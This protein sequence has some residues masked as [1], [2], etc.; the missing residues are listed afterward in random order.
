MT[1]LTQL[2]P[3]H[4]REVEVLDR[5]LDLLQ[6]DDVFN[7][8]GDRPWKRIAEP[9]MQ[10]L[11]DQHSMSEEEASWALT[12][13]GIAL[14]EITPDQPGSPL[15]ALPSESGMSGAE[16]GGSALNERRPAPWLTAPSPPLTTQR[17][18]I[19]P[20]TMV[21]MVIAIAVG[22]IASSMTFRLVENAQKGSLYRNQPAS[23]WS[24]KLQEPIQ[25][26]EV[27]QGHL[28]VLKDIDPA[29]DLRHGD[30]EAIP[31]LIELLKD[32]NSVV[33][34]EAILILGRIGKPAK[35]A[36]PALQKAL[37][38]PDDQVRARA[39]TV[40]QQLQLELAGQ[41]SGR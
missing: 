25:R 15:Q 7:S 6:A 34:Q 11:E 19:Q 12:S 10:E 20:K 40:I 35:D 29:A 38:D 24:K 2:C 4:P 33:R 14:G 26:K 18:G 5:A 17:P 39:I 1:L 13:W 30:P 36:L 21:L 28:K 23:Y 16:S 3:D 8:L 9:L 22:L 41:P 37:D 31:V 27:W 32:E